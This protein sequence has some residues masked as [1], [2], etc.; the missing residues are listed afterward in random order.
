MSLQSKEGPEG[1][2]GEMGRTG[3]PVRSQRCLFYF[4]LMA[5]LMKVFVILESVTEYSIGELC[6]QGPPGEPGE[7]G[8]PGRPGDM[9]PSL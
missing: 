7:R 3:L 8:S 6:F 5:K 4:T 9:V 2:P 1:P